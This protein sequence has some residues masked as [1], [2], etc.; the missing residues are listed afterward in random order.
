[1]DS[2]TGRGGCVLIELGSK[3]IL[4]GG[5]IT[6]FEAND[7]GGAICASNGSEFI[8]NGG[9]ITNCK[10]NKGGGAISGQCSSKQQG[11]QGED[12][13]ADVTISGGTISNNY[14]G[15]LGGG[16]RIN[17]CNLYLSGGTITNNNVGR[18]D[19]AN[20]GGG[21]ISISRSLPASETRMQEQTDHLESSIS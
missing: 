8:M 21:I 6:D 4:N 2:T 14:A 10:A 18:D 15:Q 17:R 5:T 16:V 9:T 1:M 11:P 19:G 20:G 7:E 13:C 12:I 3:M